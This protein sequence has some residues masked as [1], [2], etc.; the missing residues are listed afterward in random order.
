MEAR[1]LTGKKVKI[2]IK[3][4]L[5]VKDFCAKYEC[6]Q[7]ELM[8]RIERLFTVSGVAR[9]IWNEIVANE[10]KATKAKT[11]AEKEDI[12]DT[13]K[14]ADGVTEE[15]IAESTP[16]HVPTLDELKVSE[17]EH[18]DT[19][20]EMEKAYKACYQERDNGRKKY[21]TIRD[22]IQQ[23]KTTLEARRHEAQMIIKKDKELVERMN[24]IYAEYRIEREALEAIRSQIEELSKIVLCV[25]S[26]REIAPFDETVEIELDD[27][28]YDELFN[29]LREQEK[30]EDF[31]PKDVRVV[32]RLIR[33][34]ANLGT[35]VEIIF[36]DE[37]IKMAYE[38]FTTK[39][40]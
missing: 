7:D 2:G 8:A 39:S 1:T 10:K 11:I 37:E 18:S 19:M 12:S 14:V 5:T 23:L 40:A 4:G 20:I 22:D 25:Y 32:A 17:S 9:Q 3:N 31:R 6:T 36:E 13:T 33:I 38:I 28:G 24:G 29:L 16:P 15:E 30:A 34:V 27:S 35:P 21:Q 26:S